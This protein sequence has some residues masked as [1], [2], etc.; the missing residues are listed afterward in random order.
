MNEEELATLERNSDESLERARRD[1]SSS[2]KLPVFQ[3]GLAAAM[4]SVNDTM[5]KAKPRRDDLMTQSDSTALNMNTLDVDFDQG[6]VSAKLIAQIIKKDVEEVN[7]K[8]VQRSFPY[9]C[10]R[11][12]KQHISADSTT[13]TDPSD[14][15]NAENRVMFGNPASFSVFS[16]DQLMTRSKTVGNRLSESVGGSSNSLT[17]RASQHQKCASTDLSSMSSLTQIRLE[18]EASQPKSGPRESKWSG[19]QHV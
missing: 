7:N 6:T 18:N 1:A 5:P 3:P 8:T 13:Q 15:S 19:I 14:L 16:A 17:V 2:I 9:I 4:M 12:K 10:L 11:C